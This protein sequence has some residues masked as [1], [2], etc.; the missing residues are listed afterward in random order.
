VPTTLILDDD[1]A[2]IFWLG[3]ALD[4]A[5]CGTVPA[6]SVRSALAVLRGIGR[7]VGLVIFNPA[8]P[9]VERF[10]RDLKSQNPDLVTIAALP[11]DDQTGPPVFASIGLRKPAALDDQA[12]MEWLRAVRRVAC[13]G[14]AV[15]V[16]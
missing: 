15:P 3:L 16:R 14:G 6:Q 2:F 9:G 7:P 12:K 13:G 11:P 4:E 1:L 10:L 5:G 8:L